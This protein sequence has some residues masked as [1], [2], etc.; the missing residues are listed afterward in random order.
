LLFQFLG[1][2][3]AINQQVDSG[4]GKHWGR[5]VS[6]LGMPIGWNAKWCKLVTM[7]VQFNFSAQWFCTS[8]FVMNWFAILVAFDALEPKRTQ[9]FKFLDCV[10]DLNT[11][12]KIVTH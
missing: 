11:Q 12:V 6:A 3:F 4:G 9:V 1:C 10:M 8:I 5:F 7:D 2:N